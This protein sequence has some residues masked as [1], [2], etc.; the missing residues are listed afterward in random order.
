MSNNPNRP[1]PQTPIGVEGLPLV[2]N[3]EVL[4]RLRK[5]DRRGWDSLVEC[6]DTVCQDIQNSSPLLPKGRGHRQQPLRVGHASCRFAALGYLAPDHRLAK[7]PLGEIVGRLNQIRLA[8]ECPQDRPKLSQVFAKSH[9]LAVRRLQ[10]LANQPFEPGA[11]RPHLVFEGILGYQGIPKGPPKAERLAQFGFPL[12]PKPFGTQ[13]T[14]DQGLEIPL[15]MAEAQLPPMSRNSRVARPTIRRQNAG[16]RAKQLREGLPPATGVQSK[17]RSVGGCCGPQPDFLAPGRPPGF[18]DPDRWAALNRL[19]N[20]DCRLLDC[21][22]QPGSGLHQE[23]EGQVAVETQ[24]SLDQFLDLTSGQEQMDIQIPEKDHQCW[25][26]QG[27]PVTQRNF[28]RGNCLAGIALHAQA[29]DFSDDRLNLGKV[30]LLVNLVTDNP[31]VRKRFAATEASPGAAG[32][33]FADLVRGK[34]FAPAPWS[35]FSSHSM[36]TRGNPGMSGRIGRRRLVAV[37]G[38]RIQTSLQ[39]L[40]LGGQSRHH[41]LQL[42]D[43]ALQQGCSSDTSRSQLHLTDF[44]NKLHPPK[45]RGREHLRGFLHFLRVLHRWNQRRM[46][47]PK[48]WTL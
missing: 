10:A 14:I 45:I 36:W 24:Q 6:P 41:R 2:L 23:T 29:V 19:G 35:A 39:L 4:S 1:P 28:P 32:D 31:S 34:W 38:M 44:S 20:I 22:T 42:S 26:H 17:Q 43:L 27:W 18:V 21:S 40:N 11:H 8:N 12:S 25:T 16:E 13:A 37:S 7:H 30:D 15:Q 5:K 48:I 47:N 3:N 46:E 9:C 33:K